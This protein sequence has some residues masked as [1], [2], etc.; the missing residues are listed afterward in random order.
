MEFIQPGGRDSQGDKSGE[1]NR[2]FDSDAVESLDQKKPENG[3]QDEMKDLVLQGEK[4]GN[5][6]DRPVRKNIDQAV[7]EGGREEGGD[8]P[9]AR[10]R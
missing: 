3:V 6:A 1:P 7:I 4:P 10:L 9:H 5:S 8:F 2:F